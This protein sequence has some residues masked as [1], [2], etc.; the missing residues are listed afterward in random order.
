MYNTLL[1]TI[2]KENTKEIEFHFFNIFKEK[3]EFMFL[4][5]FHF[6]ALLSILCFIFNENDLIKYNAHDSFIRFTKIWHKNFLLF[7]N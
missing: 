7:N 6:N 5:I 2:V 3:I 1:I 4:L